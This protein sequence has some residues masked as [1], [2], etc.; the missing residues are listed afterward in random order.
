[1]NKKTIVIS[2]IN[3]RC[4][5]TFVIYKELLQEMLQNG[6]FEDFNIILLVSDKKLYAE[7][8]QKATVIEYKYS[9]ESWLLRLFYEYIY[10]YFKFYNNNI[11]LWMSLHDITPNVIA[12]NRFV[13]CHNASLFLKPDIKMLRFD[14]KLFLFSLFYKYLYLINI[15][16]NKAIIVQQ[17]WI[18]NEFQN[19]Y[20]L[21]QDKIIVA[22]PT[23]IV[24]KSRNSNIVNFKKKLFTFIYPAYPRVF[25]NFEIIGEAMMLLTPEIKRHLNI[26]LT[27]DGT[28]N[29]YAS[30][31]VSKYEKIKEMA[32]IGIV[33]REKLLEMYDCV[34]GLIFPSKLETWGLP[35]SEFMDTGKIIITADLP[36]AHE[37]I[38][39]Y[40]NVVYFNPYEAHSLAN[41]LSNIVLNKLL[42]LNYRNANRGSYIRHEGLY[43]NSWN[44]LLQIILEKCK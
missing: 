17:E 24:K 9:K 28:E 32:F 29:K 44:S 27:I 11:Y 39:N 4:G 18:K 40:R 8:M 10:F 35:L 22:H 43:A 3:L 20:L 19:I 36:Y 5:G 42:V 31:I 21:P 7:Y 41:I 37:T 26:I 30:Y 33:K 25:K 34:D 14:K 15:H 12:K 2:G 13:Y 6:M 38:D 1:M 16:K 23:H